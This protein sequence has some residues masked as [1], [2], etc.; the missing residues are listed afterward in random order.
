MDSIMKQAIYD[1]STLEYDS[2]DGDDLDD[3]HCDG[4]G[5]DVKY[6]KTYTNL[7]GNATLCK[8]CHDSVDTYET[9]FS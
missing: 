5:K 2:D 3:K 7:W 6:S 8:K 4:C 1:Y 9:I